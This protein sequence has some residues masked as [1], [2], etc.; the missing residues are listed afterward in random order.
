MLR[1]VYRETG[2]VLELEPWAVFGEIFRSVVS[3][4]KWRR[5]NNID[6]VPSSQVYIYR[7]SDLVGMIVVSDFDLWF[8]MDWPDGSSH[9]MAVG[10]GW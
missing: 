1:M 4:L 3:D 7:D 10:R 6:S 2:E 9:H 8:S 5:K